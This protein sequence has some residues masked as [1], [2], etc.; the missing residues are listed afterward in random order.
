M[1]HCHFSIL[2]NEIAF[3]KQKLPFLY[4]NFDQIIF[5]DL[6]I[7]T[8][9]FS[10]DG[11]HEFIK[12]YPDPENKITLIEKT[13]LK[14]VDGY[15]G[16]S[17]IE[18][19]KMFAVGSSYVKDDMDVFWCTDMDEFFTKELINKVENLYNTT[20]NRTILVPHLVFFKNDKYIFSKNKT[21]GERWVLPWAR[22]TKHTPGNVYGHCSL[23]TQFG[24]VGSILDEEIFHFSYVGDEK[25]ANKVEGYG[26]GVWVRDVWNQFDESNIS[27]EEREIYGFPEMHPAVNRG[28]IK[29][30][31]KIPDYINV[32]EMLKDLK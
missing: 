28:I 7:R 29:N 13:D 24:P 3:L 18:K 25:V 12:D 2:W 31:Y 32:E 8:S 19:R 5:F 10:T 20:D 4:K 16:I 22:I 17:Y 30:K 1:K 21:G 9:A 23:N 15:I 27:F 6:N 11:S 26:H 14:D